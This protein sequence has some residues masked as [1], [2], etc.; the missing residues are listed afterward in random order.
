[1]T[2]TQTAKLDT[3][4]LPPALPLTACF[5]TLTSR[6]RPELLSTP[7]LPD[8]GASTG[9]ALRWHSWSLGQWRPR[10]TLFAVIPSQ[11]L[12]VPTLTGVLN[13]PPAPPFLLT[14]SLAPRLTSSQG[15]IPPRFSAPG[16]RAHLVL[17]RRERRQAETGL[18][19]RHQAQWLPVHFQL[20]D[21]RL[22]DPSLWPYPPCL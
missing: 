4:P 15:A 11:S 21:H 7:L 17:E 10:R 22:V 5:S 1:M 9:P 20:R 2:T 16:V 3:R 6:A 19:C 8:T 12:P 18:C 13:P 14:P